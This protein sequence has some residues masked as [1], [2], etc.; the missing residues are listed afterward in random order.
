MRAVVPGPLAYHP[1][2][3]PAYHSPG[4]PVSTTDYGRASR[5]SS[6]PGF[7]ADALDNMGWM[8]LGVGVACAGAALLA[9]D[10]RDT[11]TI[12]RHGAKTLLDEQRT[13]RNAGAVIMSGMGIYLILT[14]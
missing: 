2:Y 3:P 1:A 8:I 9:D 10:A 6:S 13:L 4:Y 11:D 5:R 12:K 14:T 7:F